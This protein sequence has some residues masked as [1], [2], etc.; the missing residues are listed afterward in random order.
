MLSNI[1]LVH[2]TINKKD[3]ITVMLSNI[4]LV[5]MTINKKEDVFSH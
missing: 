2:M 1:V 3:E 5:H 4:V